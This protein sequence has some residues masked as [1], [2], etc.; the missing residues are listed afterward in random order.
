M[1]EEMEMPCM[2]DCG[3]WFDLHDGVKSLHSNKVICEDCFGE[4]EREDK[5]EQLQSQIDDLESDIDFTKEQIEELENE[6]EQKT[7]EK[8][9]LEQELKELEKQIIMKNL[10]MLVCEV[11]G[12]ED[13]Q[14]KA[15]VDINKKKPEIEFVDFGDENDNWCKS[16]EAH[17]NFITREQYEENI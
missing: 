15:W 7:R 16:C 8:E 1:K 6:I 14:G 17:V 11:C 4:E 2:C 9:E 13:I 3:N 10:Q 5:I 12:S